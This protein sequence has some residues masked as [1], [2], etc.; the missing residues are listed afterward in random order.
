MVHAQKSLTTRGNVNVHEVSQVM[1]VEVRCHGRFLD[2]LTSG[3]LSVM[4]GWPSIDGSST[5]KG[6]KPV[7]K[8]VQA[9]LA[10]AGIPQDFDGRPTSKTMMGVNTF[11]KAKGLQNS[12]ALNP[13]AWELLVK[14]VKKGMGTDPQSTE[15]NIVLAVQMLL[16]RRFAYNNPLSGVFDYKTAQDVGDFQNRFGLEV[17]DGIVDKATWNKL[18]GDASSTLVQWPLEGSYQPYPDQQVY[19]AQDTTGTSS[20]NCQLHGSYVWD[21]DIPGRS[22]AYPAFTSALFRKTP[23]GGGTGLGNTMGRKEGLPNLAYTDKDGVRRPG[24]KSLRFVTVGVHDGGY[25]E[26]NEMKG[27]D[28]GAYSMT[29]EMWFKPETISQNAALFSTCDDRMNGFYLGYRGY[30]LRV[31]VSAESLLDAPVKFFEDTWHH[32]AAT[33]EGSKT[34]TGTLKLY[35]DAQKIGE[36]VVPDNSIPWRQPKD[37]VNPLIGAFS[38]NLEQ[39]RFQ[40]AIDNVRISRTALASKDFLMSETPTD[41]NPETAFVVNKRAIFDKL[42]F[43]YS[44]VRGPGSWAKLM[45][46]NEECS[47]SEAQSPI[48][49]PVPDSERGPRDVSFQALPASHLKYTEMAYHQSAVKMFYLGA[50]MGFTFDGEPGQLILNDEHFEA[51]EVLFHTPSEHTIGGLPVEMEMQ[52]IHKEKKSNRT[53]IV[54]V[55]FKKGENN[56]VLGPVFEQ[57]V[58]L[59]AIPQPSAALGTF[60]LLDVIPFDPG[61]LVYNGSLTV[62]PCTEGVLWVIL[63]HPSTAS[64]EQIDVIRNVMGDNARPEQPRN[65]RAVKRINAGS[66]GSMSSLL[67]RMEKLYLERTTTLEL[68]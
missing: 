66:S 43:A 38:G 67:Q 1:I 57:I 28:N 64:G 6:M 37:A 55:L 11:V 50:Q 4:A 27:F 25:A 56:T 32:V 12:K 15:R 46:E 40:G 3:M 54:S 33:F 30:F 51:K 26:C 58:K 62:P 2:A 20:F 9:L 24:Q 49:L 39:K 16:N 19:Y 14:D 36:S 61:L 47:T 21:F 7:V 17:S 10:D 60:D 45:P 23:P 41:M 48:D 44:G 5:G 65:G 63:D 8:A 52:I 13:K 53:A 68:D 18:V 34:G 29:V 22:A 35:L 31:S 59:G 42:P